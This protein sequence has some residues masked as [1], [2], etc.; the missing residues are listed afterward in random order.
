MGSQERPQSLGSLLGHARD[1]LPVLVQ[2]EAA[3]GCSDSQHQ[4]RLP[5]ARGSRGC[6][7]RGWCGCV[8]VR[9]RVRASVCA[10][11][12]GWDRC[13]CACASTCV[14]VCKNVDMCDRTRACVRMHYRFE[15]HCKATD[16]S[17]STASGGLRGAP[18]GSDKSG[19]HTSVPAG[20]GFGEGART[21]GRPRCSCGHEYRDGQGEGALKHEEHVTGHPSAALTRVTH[22]SSWC[23]DVPTNLT[24]SR[25]SIRWPMTRGHLSIFWQRASRRVGAQG[26]A[27]GETRPTGRSA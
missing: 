12:S 2:L 7:R 6:A 15:R 25:G 4:G 18:R 19:Q 1:I 11:V 5:P 3:V 9:V 8:S 13:A 10:C 26:Q 24:T 22:L 17:E 14:C 23:R 20:Y 27:E 21:A 16:P